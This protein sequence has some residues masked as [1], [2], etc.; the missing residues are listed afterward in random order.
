[1]TIYNAVAVSDALILPND[2]TVG[3]IWSL[4]HDYVNIFIAQGIVTLFRSGSASVPFGIRVNISDSCLNVGWTAHQPVSYNRSSLVIGDITVTGLDNC[5]H[6]RSKPVSGLLRCEEEIARRLALLHDLC[7]E[8]DRPGGILTYLGD[9]V[10]PYG[11]NKPVTGGTEVR[12]RQRLRALVSGTL[13]DDE[14]QIVE[15][16]SGLLGFGPGLTPSGDDFLLG[17]LGG[18]RCVC[19]DY[20]WS[21]A[22]K[23]AWHMAH[24]APKLTTLLA[25]EYIRYGVQEYYHQCLYELINAFSTGSDAALTDKAYRL[26]ALG[27][28]SGLDLLIGFVYGG[29]TS[30]QLGMTKKGE[31]NANL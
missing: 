24:N 8:A 16:V 27:H 25:S 23:M 9:Y 13:L 21:A 20:C 26:L 4:H 1:M 10:T 31:T 14:Y 28:Q 7:R 18:L 3:E 30:L 29:L 11:V 22:E 6:F 17:F 5:S 2:H 15:G 12:I 19:P